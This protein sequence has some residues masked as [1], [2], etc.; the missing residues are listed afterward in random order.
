MVRNI[1]EKAQSRDETEP[2]V[3]GPSV[4]DQLQEELEEIAEV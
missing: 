3:S 4:Y 1:D 2:G